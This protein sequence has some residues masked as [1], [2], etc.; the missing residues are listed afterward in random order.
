MG[1]GHGGDRE[2]GGQSPIW[3]VG[4]VSPDREQRRRH[5]PAVG[6]TYLSG[7]ATTYY[8]SF[9]FNG[10]PFQGSGLGQYAGVS[11]Y[12]ASD[13]SNSLL[14]GMPGDSGGLG[15]DWT[16]RGAPFQAASDNTNYLILLKI[17]PGATTGKTGVTMFVTTDLLMGGADLAATTPWDSMPDE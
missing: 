15:F 1:R 6:T 5:L 10:N 11:V 2:S 3:H 9:V 17:A 13:T 12:L 8:I 14:G 4:E 16:N 7:G